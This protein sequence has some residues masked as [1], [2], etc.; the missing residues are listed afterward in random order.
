LTNPLFNVVIVFILAFVITWQAIPRIIWIATIKNLTD[1]P[2]ARKLQKHAV[3]TLGGIGIFAG[4]FIAFMLV[5]DGTI[6]KITTVSAGLMVILFLGIKDDLENLTPFQKL[7][8]EL[9]AAVIVACFSG[10]CFTNFHGLFNIFAINSAVSVLFTLGFIIFTMNS[11][12]LIDGIDGLAAAI[13]LFVSLMYGL[14]FFLAGDIGYAIMCAALAGALSGF[15][16]F[17][18]SRGDKKI[19]MGDTGSLC[20]GFL[21]SIMTIRFNEM[22][23]LQSNPLRFEYAPLISL[24]LLV[25]PYFDTLR[26]VI[27][28]LKEGRHPFSADQNHM[29]HRLLRL[30]LSHNKATIALLLVNGIVFLIAVIINEFH[31][32]LSL[33]VIS[34]LCVFLCR[35]TLLLEK[36]RGVKEAIKETVSAFAIYALFSLDILF[37]LI[38]ILII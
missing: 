29:H 25:I 26:V 12:N 19:F 33:I 7:A 32:L 16:P 20:I 27:I 17:N 4:F 31:F 6:D 34:G 13:G 18:L 22:N 1:R 3:P 9:M 38:F 10:L 30:G 28:R 35:F 24:S 36:R 23:A 8:T 5:V 15:L 37:M 11:F 2:G 21:L 14:W